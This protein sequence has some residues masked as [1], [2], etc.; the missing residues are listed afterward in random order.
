VSSEVAALTTFYGPHKT[1]RPYLVAIV[2]D[3]KQLRQRSLR[4]LYGKWNKTYGEPL[5]TT[6][7]QC[8]TLTRPTPLAP[9]P[10]SSGLAP[11]SVSAICAEEAE[12]DPLKPDV[13]YNMDTASTLPYGPTTPPHTTPTPPV[14]CTLLTILNETPKPTTLHKF[15]DLVVAYVHKTNL[16]KTKKAIQKHTEA[17]CRPCVIPRQVVATLSRESQEDP[18]SDVVAAPVLFT[19][20]YQEVATTVDYN[21]FEDDDDDD[22]FREPAPVPVP[23]PVRTNI[24]DTM[25]M[26]E[27]EDRMMEPVNHVVPTTYRWTTESQET[28]NK[29]LLSGLTKI[30]INFDATIAKPLISSGTVELDSIYVRS[31]LLTVGLRRYFRYQPVRPVELNEVYI[32]EPI[33]VPEVPVT[34]TRLEDVPFRPANPTSPT[35]EAFSPPAPEPSIEPPIIEPPMLVPV[36]APSILLAT[37]EVRSEVRRSREPP[38][39]PPRLPPK[40]KAAAEPKLEVCHRDPPMLGRSPSRKSFRLH[41]PHNK[42]DRLGMYTKMFLDYAGCL[43]TDIMFLIIS[44]IGLVKNSQQTWT[45]PVD[46]TYW[47]G[48][49]NYWRTELDSIMMSSGYELPPFGYHSHTRSYANSTFPGLN[50]YQN[51][52]KHINDECYRMKCFMEA[53]WKDLKYIRDENVISAEHQLEEYI[54]R[55]KYLVE[56]LRKR[57]KN[58]KKDQ[59]RLLAMAEPVLEKEHKDDEPLPVVSGCKIILGNQEQYMEE[60]NLSD[61]DFEEEGLDLIGGSRPFIPNL[62]AKKNKKQ[63]R[64]TPE[65]EARRQAEERARVAEIRRIEAEDMVANLVPSMPHTY[66]SSDLY[67]PLYPHGIAGFRDTDIQ[68]IARRRRRQEDLSIALR[69]QRGIPRRIPNRSSRPPTVDDQIRPLSPERTPPAPEPSISP[70]FP[71]RVP[72]SRPLPALPPAP[73]MEEIEEEEEEFDP[74]AILTPPSEEEEKKEYK[75]EKEYKEP[76]IEIY[77]PFNQIVGK[78]DWEDEQSGMMLPEFVQ[79]N[80]APPGWTVSLGKGLGKPITFIDEEGRYVAPP[81]KK[82]GRPPKYGPELPPQRPGRPRKEYRRKVLKVNALGQLEEVEIV[83]RGIGSREFAKRSRQLQRGVEQM[84]RNRRQKPSQRVKER[85]IALNIPGLSDHLTDVYKR[86]IRMR[87]GQKLTYFGFKFEPL[88]QLMRGPDFA[89]SEFATSTMVH[90]LDM[91]Q[92]QTLHLEDFLRRSL[93]RPLSMWRIIIIYTNQNGQHITSTTWAGSFER[94]YNLAQARIA[95]LMG[96]YGEDNIVIDRWEV[97]VRIMRGQQVL[98]G[99]RNT[100]LDE[101]LKTLESKWVVVNP[102]S[103]TNCLWTSVAICCGFQASPDLI[104]NRKAQNRA[105]INLKRKVGTRNEKGG[106]EEDLEKCAT[107]KSLNIVVHNQADEVITQIV[108]RGDAVGD[109]HVMLHLGHY[110]SLLPKDNQVVKDNVTLMVDAEPR[111]LQM[112]KQLKKEFTPRKIC[113]YDLESYKE[114]MKIK[115]EILEEIDQVA[116]AIGWAVEI[117]SIGEWTYMLEQGYE[118]IPADLGF[119]KINIAY[120]RLLGDTCLDDAIHEWMHLPIFDQA[121]FYAH[122]GGKFD[123]RLILGQSD[124]LYRGN[125]VAV[126]EKLIE[127]NG[128]LINMD[129]KNTFMEYTEP[130]GKTRSHYISFRDSLPLFGPDASLAKLTTELNV[131]HKKLEEKINVHDMQFKDTWEANWQKYEMDI[132]LRNDV[133]GLLEVLIKFNKEVVEGTQIPIS[134]VNTGASLSKKYY[135]KHH[136]HNQNEEGINDP[137]LSIYTLD[138]NMDSFIREGYGGGRCEAFR[139]GE[140]NQKVYYYD[141]TSL[142]PDVGRMKMPIGQPKWLCEPD[143]EEDMEMIRGVWQQRVIERRTFGTTCFWKVNM[144]SP[145]AA[146]GTPMDTLKRK[147]L[148][149][150]KEENMYLFRWYKD[151][152]ELVIYEE[153]LKFAIDMGLDYEFEPINAIMFNHQEVLKS[154]MEDLFKKKAQAKADGKPGLSKTWKIIINSLYGVWG[155]KVLDREG[156]EIARPEHSS[157]AIDLVTEKLKDVEKIGR[158][159]VSRRIRDLEVKDCNVAI[160]AAVTAEARM[161]LYRLFIDIQDRGGEIL[162]CDTDSIITNFCIEENVEMN[163]KWIGPSKGK[164]LGSL[165]NEIE[166]CYEKLQKKQPNITIKPYF[167]H[168]IIV[169]PKFYI[170]T[171]EHEQIVKKGNK[172]WKEQPGDEITYQRMKILVDKE[173]PEIE[174]ILEQDTIQWLGGNADIMKNQIGVRLVKRHK[175]IQGLC[176]DGHPINKG[177]L[178]EDGVVEPFIQRT[179][180]RKHKKPQ[181]E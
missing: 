12:W 68:A 111:P 177:T 172:G 123:L 124:L 169:S 134:S 129:V 54:K 137:T 148:F 8:I 92:R 55:F 65:E 33:D 72:P 31:N 132:Y 157:W 115:G 46:T 35:Y 62:H 125:Y 181:R 5:A 16:A 4:A 52:M 99:G 128:R 53:E 80:Y 78:F 67:S 66:Y 88:K 1:L 133:I 156:I 42:E 162:Y 26:D 13:S 130:D 154:C 44:H 153:E 22:L 41:W 11:A 24:L 174:R 89:I 17:G 146:Q 40:M 179:E 178:R 163:N 34:Y 151:W 51:E 121:V 175:V 90:A 43:P 109:I 102:K 37:P 74:F 106:T 93:D 61:S 45:E 19:S 29:R 25:T 176:A 113:T 107:Y 127:L 82:M 173:I 91:F 119:E 170:V 84:I 21:E 147:P 112:I 79:E 101:K 56:K 28:T 86:S 168:A 96:R 120:K 6:L 144:R 94:C 136:Y 105:G 70:R 171:A 158:Y 30:E 63:R 77:D 87:P 164:D 64:L 142:Y 160:A 138:R 145:L 165:K 116:Y 69:R 140:I 108:P 152:T 71:F 149:G 58:V 97:R 150:L 36:I 83:E 20:P 95:E 48:R 47:R 167:D 59:S 166:E 7:N 161:K 60:N 15:Q 9:V 39:T 110:H 2:A 139:V 57:F 100:I 85:A 135:L 103:K 114:P 131:P 159:V 10:V 81:K 14:K 27:L 98:A 50:C 23:V 76:R 104:H 126:P 117:Q 141:F 75:E 73:T 18:V 143:S 118:V 122:N 155:L 49:Y 32:V 180:R 38:R 3:M